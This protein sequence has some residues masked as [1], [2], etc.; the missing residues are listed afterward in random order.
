MFAQ[1]G[2]LQAQGLIIQTHPFA[3]DGFF[4]QIYQLVQMADRG[5]L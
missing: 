5:D 2:Y 4:V 3:A 1:A